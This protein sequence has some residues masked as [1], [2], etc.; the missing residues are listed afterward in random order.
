M[1]RT[2]EKCFEREKGVPNAINT[3][4]TWWYKCFW[5]EKDVFKE[6]NVLDAINIFVALPHISAPPA[7]GKDEETPPRVFWARK[8][9]NMKKRSCAL[10]LNQS[11]LVLVLCALCMLP[12]FVGVARLLLSWYIYGLDHWAELLGQAVKR[13]KPLSCARWLNSSFLFDLWALCSSP[14]RPP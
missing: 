12:C 6:N 3:F 7:R 9:A 13:P 5:R 10:W 1:F 8:R 2:R 14:L 4:W 11:L